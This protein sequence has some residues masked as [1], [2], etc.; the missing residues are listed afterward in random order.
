MQS[1]LRK[2]RSPVQRSAAG[3]A[4]KRAQKHYGKK[5][6]PF[7]Q[8]PQHTAEKTVQGKYVY[9]DFDK[10][11]AKYWQ[12]LDTIESST[13]PYLN[14]FKSKYGRVE[15][16]LDDSQDKNPGS[17]SKI[18]KPK[19]GNW[20]HTDIDEIRQMPEI[21]EFGAIITIRKWYFQKYSIGKI[22][23]MLAHEVG[24]HIVPYMKEI[25]LK[26]PQGAQT[27][28]GIDFSTPPDTSKQSGPSGIIDHQR[29]ATIGSEDFFLYQGVI[30]DLVNS[31]IEQNKHKLS[32]EEVNFHA[33]DLADAY[34]MD[35]STFLGSGRRTVIPFFAQS[36]A[37]KYNKYETSL[38][39]RG[40]PKRVSRGMKKKKAV[41]V[42][43]DY[44]TLYKN[45][46]A[47]AVRQ[48]PVVST[49]IAALLVLTLIYFIYR[50]FS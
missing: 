43:S 32:G 17:A 16:H 11:D 7:E 1:S 18:V 3:L 24:V 46:L 4:G 15:I 39:I 10:S 9:V 36:I 25:G 37:N 31:I 35:I 38:S 23:S 8:Q 26:M 42:R 14:F 45:V 40:L 21:D 41:D 50:I 28:M 27:A 6:A 12:L 22:I 20:Q 13:N 30:I 34:L 29:V 49:T 5:A 19:G 44:S 47:V 33:R 2:T 48:H